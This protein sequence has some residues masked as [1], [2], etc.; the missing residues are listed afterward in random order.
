MVTFLGD[1]G[2]RVASDEEKDVFDQMRKVYG[3]KEWEEVSGLKTKDRRKVNREMK[4]IDGLIHNLVKDGM[5]VSEINR[6]LYTG[7]YVVA[8]S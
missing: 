4:I 8:D 2:L 3:R 6:L 1:D 5:S 7:S